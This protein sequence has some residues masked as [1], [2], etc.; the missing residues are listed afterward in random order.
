M[1][2]LTDGQENPTNIFTT[3]SNQVYEKRITRVKCFSLAAL[4]RIISNE[5][6]RII[7]QAKNY[8]CCS[9]AVLYCTVLYVLYCTVLYWAQ[10][11]PH[12]PSGNFIFTGN[13]RRE[14]LNLFPA[15][16]LTISPRNL[17][18][19]IGFLFGVC[20]YGWI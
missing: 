14:L 9:A 16:P 6:L 7:T 12:S 10:E 19:I 11:A 17:S 3:R 4:M 5:Y 2:D 13:F 1:S 15:C 8:F 20:F 18:W